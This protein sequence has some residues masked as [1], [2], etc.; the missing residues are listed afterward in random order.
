MHRRQREWLLR[1][2]QPLPDQAGD[3]PGR[4]TEKRDI[5]ADRAM[6]TELCGRGFGMLS[7]GAFARQ[8]LPH[9]I[10]RTEAAEA[11][12][13]ELEGALTYIRDIVFD[14]ICAACNYPS[15]TE[16]D[17]CAFAELG[18]CAVRALAGKEVAR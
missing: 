10:D 4:E 3:R 13:A 1:T 9:Y 2:G 5:A 8:V 14:R 7:A 6:F 12:V 11:R 16:C 17:T 18:G 15:T